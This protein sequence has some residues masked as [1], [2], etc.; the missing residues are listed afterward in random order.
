MCSLNCYGSNRKYKVIIN[1][2]GWFCELAASFAQSIK[3]KYYS[4]GIQ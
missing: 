4:F 2:S 3:I 1:R